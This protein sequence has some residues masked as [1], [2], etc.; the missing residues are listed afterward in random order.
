METEAKE[1]HNQSNAASGV[2][3][4]LSKQLCEFCVGFFYLLFFYAAFIRPVFSQ[5]DWKM[6]HN[7]DSEFQSFRDSCSCLIFFSFYN[8][9][10]YNTVL[11]RATGYVCGKNG[12]FGIEKKK[13]THNKLSIFQIQEF[14]LSYIQRVKILT[15]AAVETKKMKTEK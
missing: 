5:N 6:D 1:N 10:P 2:K 11:I 9:A 7:W 3:S 14:F 4:W 8:A 15:D 12:R 13:H